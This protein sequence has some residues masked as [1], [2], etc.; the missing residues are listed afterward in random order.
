VTVTHDTG[1]DAVNSLTINESLQDGFVLSG[2]SV[3]LA[4]NSLIGNT[5]SF[6]LSGGTLTGAGSL[7]VNGPLGWSGGVMAGTGATVAQGGLVLNPTDSYLILDQRTL[8]NASNATY[9]GPGTLGMIVDDGATITNLA[10]ATWDFQIDASINTTQGAVGTFTNQGTLLKSAGTG[11]PNIDIVFNNSG[12]VL[13]ESGTLALSGGGTDSGSFTVNAG[14]TLAFS[15][16]THSLLA[17]ASLTGAGTVL[18]SGGTVNESGS[19]NITGNTTIAGGTVNFN[20]G[21]A[22]SVPVLTESGGALGGSDEIIVTGTLTWTGGSMAGTGVTDVA[23]GGFLNINGGN[24]YG[25]LRTINNEGTNISVNPGNVFVSTDSTFTQLES[26]VASGLQSLVSDLGLLY[27]NLI[28]LLGHALNTIPGSLVNE[29]LP[30]LASTIQGISL[31]AIQ[32]DLFQVLGPP[33]LDV[34]RLNGASPE[35]IPIINSNGM[36]AITLPIGKGLSVQAPFDLGLPGLPLQLNASGSVQGSV[37]VNLNLHFSVAQL[38]GQSPSIKIDP[39]VLK[40]VVAAGLP[41]LM[42]S[43]QLGLLQAEAADDPTKPSALNLVYV[44]NFSTDASGNLMVLTATTGGAYVNLLLSASFTGD[45]INDPTVTTEFQLGWTFSQADPAQPGPFG[46]TPSVAFNNIQLH[47]GSFEGNF[48]A[49]V[50]SNVQIVTRPL[51]PLAEL[52]LAPLPV[53]SDLATDVGLPPVRLA[54]LLGANGPAITNFAMAVEIINGLDPTAL[55]SGVIHLGNF[56]V[57]DPRA[58]DSA[59]DATPASI[60]QDNAARDV[61]E[62]ISALSPDAANFE[63][64]MSMLDSSDGLH[65]TILDDPTNAFDLLLGKDTTLFTYTLTPVM[66]STSVDYEVP[67]YPGVLVDFGGELKLSVSATFGCDSTGLHTGHILDSFYLQDASVTV[68]LTITA[69]GGVGIPD[70]VSLTVNGNLG[71]S[72]TFTLTGADGSSRLTE[73]ELANGQYTIAKSGDIYG[74]LSIDVHVLGDKVYG[75]DFPQ[76]DKQIF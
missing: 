73:S 21:A 6:N 37:D 24:T 12:T 63:N 19:Y 32:Q 34:L 42:A 16:G 44:T 31:S 15:R 72:V 7:T 2:G 49:P 27:G 71:I 58:T 28:P 41:G 50:L 38:A 3:S 39:S 75:Y 45:P 47:L 43:A 76:F 18:F 55:Q 23:P 17:S 4:G 9:S 52:L 5:D 29:V 30:G 74:Y 46:D 59:G 54:D 25:G 69:G 40:A 70:T 22:V 53:I 51:E 8:S 13:A 11:T 14:A 64:Q 67:V 33:G 36:V 1:S 60:L 61:T 68:G 10:G 20:T 26:F 48:L 62:Q 66:L 65:F 56:T 57:I 35:F